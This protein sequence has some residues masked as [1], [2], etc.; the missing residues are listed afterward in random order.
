M[1]PA[2]PDPAIVGRRLRMLSDTLGELE[3]LSDV[4]AEQLTSEA[5]TRAAAE[6]LIQVVVDLAVDVNSHLV[7]SITGAAPQTGRESFLEAGRAGII[8]EQ[9]AAELAPAAGLR[10]V[11]VHRYTEIRVDLVAGAISDVLA[12]FPTYVREVARFLEERAPEED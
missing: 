4:S 9:L 11:L 1:T 2:L 8:P 5:I 6:R 10:N 3:Q 12:R 7:V